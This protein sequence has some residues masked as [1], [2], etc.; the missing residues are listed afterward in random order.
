MCGRE[1][2]VERGRGNVWMGAGVVLLKIGHAVAHE[3]H[4]KGTRKSVWRARSLFF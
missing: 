3:K 2:A 1:S 4:V